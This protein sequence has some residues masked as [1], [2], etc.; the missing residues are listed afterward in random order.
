MSCGV[1]RIRNAYHKDTTL[2]KYDVGKEFPGSPRSA[3]RT[4]EIVGEVVAV[5]AS[6]VLRCCV[7]AFACVGKDILACLFLRL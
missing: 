5:V 6:W 7:S 4:E 2:I 1:E 3:S